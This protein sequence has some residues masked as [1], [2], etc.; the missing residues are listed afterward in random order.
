[1][2]TKI[3]EKHT[4]F[5]FKGNLVYIDVW[6]GMFLCVSILTVEEST[7]GSI[8]KMKAVC[9]YN[10]RY[11]PFS[12]TTTCRNLAGHNMSFRHSKIWR[13]PDIEA[14][15]VCACVCVCVCVCLCLS[16]FDVPCRTSQSL[17]CHPDFDIY[18]L[19]LLLS[20]FL[21]PVIPRKSWKIKWEMFLYRCVFRHWKMYTLKRKKDDG[22]WQYLLL[23]KMSGWISNSACK[24]ALT[25][26]CLV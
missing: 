15:G 19:F 20:L 14:T 26:T 1:M 25:L 12:P 17:W 16:W 6:C 8:L 21:L 24:T 23:P 11:P 4:I 9:C 22:L 18:K 3:S 7:F 10:H 5:F 2:G 13:L